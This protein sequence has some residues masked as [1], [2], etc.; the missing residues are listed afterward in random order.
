MST[1][2]YTVVFER[3]P[4]GGYHAFCPALPGCHS[5][6]DTLDDA[7]ANI[8]EAAELYVESLMAH[9]EPVPVEDILI[10]PIEVAAPT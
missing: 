5:Q 1:H 8:R 9:S 7:M 4:D 3:E 6:G 10:K 2:R